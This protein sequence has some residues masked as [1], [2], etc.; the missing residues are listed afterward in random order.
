MKRVYIKP[1][2]VKSQVTLQAVTAG[3]KTTGPIRNP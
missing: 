3:G 2:L 1:V